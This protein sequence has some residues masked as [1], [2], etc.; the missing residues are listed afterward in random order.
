VSFPRRDVTFLYASHSQP[1]APLQP[2]LVAIALTQEPRFGG[3]TLVASN[4]YHD[5]RED[6]AEPAR[7]L[8]K[9]G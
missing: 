7:I 4:Y 2:I 8:Y 1:I 5:R 3:V 6:I 9:G